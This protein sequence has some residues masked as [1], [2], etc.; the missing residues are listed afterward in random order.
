M[1]LSVVIPTLGGIELEDTIEALQN[2]SIRP[3]EILICIPSSS[4]LLAEIDLSDNIEIIR[5]K[6]KGQVYQRMIGFLATKGEQ[7]LQLDDDIILEKDAIKR[8]VYCLDS[9]SGKAAISPNLLKQGTNQ[10]AFSRNSN[11]ISRR[12][13]DWILNGSSGYKPGVLSL[14]GVGFDLDFID[15]TQDKIESEWIAG[16]CILHRS[17][18]LIT[19]DFFPF[20]G[21]A[22]SEDLIHSILL[23][24][25][26]VKLFVC[27]NAIAYVGATPY[28]DSLIEFYRQY[29]AT[30]YAV[31]LQRKG[32]VRLN[33]FS[34]LRLIKIILRVTSKSVLSFLKKVF[35]IK[36]I[37]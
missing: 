35:K 32:F 8:L 34:F 5:T 18:N 37:L 3:M 33:L 23:R 29:Q 19:K 17:Q 13:S 30:K 14:S 1:N 36:K 16:T 4:E 6:K 21:K 28:P 25:N 20:S 10:S 31:N 24:Q 15:I 22:Y 7:V 27:N 11:T 12:F 26:G 9:S 2:S